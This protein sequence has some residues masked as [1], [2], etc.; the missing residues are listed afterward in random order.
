MKVNDV[1]TVVAV[2]GAE[3]VGKFRK[4]TDEAVVIGDPHIVSPVNETIQF[5]PTVA[6]TGRTNIGEVSFL[7]SGIILV[8]P[9][10]KEVANEYTK[11][12]SGIIL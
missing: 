2:T 12:V 7:K 6:M 3:Y 8:V 4:S 5:M 9:T 11:A 1:V 10:A